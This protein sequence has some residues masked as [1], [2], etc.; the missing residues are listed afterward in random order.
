[1]STA[2]FEDPRHIARKVALK[3]LFWQTS[4]NK[5]KTETEDRIRFPDL[6]NPEPKLTDKIVKGVSK[7]QAELNKIITECSPD[8]EI[9]MMEGVDLQILRIAIYEGFIGNFTPQKAAINEAV[10]LAKEYGG[11]DSSK[12]INGVL[13]A[14]MDNYGDKV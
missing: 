10:E 14:V 12:F 2:K 11:E 4:T 8:W 6:Q 5:F 9:S 13:G 1:M 3:Q 7:Y